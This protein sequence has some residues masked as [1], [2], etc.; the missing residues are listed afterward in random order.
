M[1]SVS[2]PQVCAVKL[3]FRFTFS[4]SLDLDVSGLSE[5]QMHV[6][7]SFTG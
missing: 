6:L 2:N 1:T 3:R 4:H 5:V 7:A